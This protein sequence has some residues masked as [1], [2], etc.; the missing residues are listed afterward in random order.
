MIDPG[1]AGVVAAVAG[2]VIA[3]L[4]RIEHRITR[5]EVLL[6]TL[7]DRTGAAPARRWGDQP[8]GGQ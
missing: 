6:H 8:E 2:A 3:W 4:V 5:V 1:T 7:I